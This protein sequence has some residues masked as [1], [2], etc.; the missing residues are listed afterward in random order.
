[1]YES[2][3]VLI[4]KYH[5]F[6]LT[7]YITVLLIQTLDEKKGEV[8]IG[9]TMTKKSSKYNIEWDKPPSRTRARKVNCGSKA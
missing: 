2:I 9:T 3:E 6:L 5:E 7:P 1:L 4:R 8:G